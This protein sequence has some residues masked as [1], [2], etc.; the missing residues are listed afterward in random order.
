MIFFVLYLTIGAI[1]GRL[2][3]GPAILRDLYGDPDG[4]TYGLVT[5]M[6]L[7]WPITLFLFILAFI[8]R[9]LLPKDPR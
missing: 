8:G 7:G 3:F 6:A 1:L 4:F 2:L 9:F 5:L